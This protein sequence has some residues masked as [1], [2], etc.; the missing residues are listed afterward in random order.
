MFHVKQSVLAL[1]L[2]LATAGPAAA[3]DRLTIILDWF[4]NANPRVAAV[5]AI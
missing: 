1:L 3:A 4:M 5:G 2:G